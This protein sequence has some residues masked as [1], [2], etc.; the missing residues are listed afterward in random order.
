MEPVIVKFF[1]IFFLF[2]QS[3]SIWGNLI[4]SVV[5]SLKAENVTVQTENEVDLSTCGINYC[6]AAAS[7]QTN[8]SDSKAIEESPGPD[9]RLYILAGVYLTCSIL[10]AIV[11]ALFVDPLSK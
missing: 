5:L 11:V 9:Y 10:S 6:P 2:F 4:S 3:S 1:G 7:V 8:E